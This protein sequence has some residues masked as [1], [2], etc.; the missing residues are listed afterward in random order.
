[1]SSKAR[2]LPFWGVVIVI[3]LAA[4]WPVAPASANPATFVF[5]SVLD[6]ACTPGSYPAFM[7]DY[8]VGANEYVNHV[9]TLTNTRTGDVSAPWVVG[10]ISGP[11]SYHKVTTIAYTAVP[12]GTKGD[13]M[14]ER[15]DVVNARSGALVT[16]DEISYFCGGPGCS[17]PIPATAVVGQFLDN[18]TTYWQPGYMTSPPVVIEV[19]KT[20]WTLGV[21]A[22][23]AFRK[24][25]WACQYLWV[26]EGSMGPNYDDVWHGTPLPMD[27]VE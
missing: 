13:L 17:L 15:V 11:G 6:P 12:A 10:P 27:V 25:I 3:L 23:G 20:A 4:L 21:D 22:T 7:F 9:W 18:T 14:V 26:P 5:T 24:I 16:Y 8:S 1:M 19:G 2:R